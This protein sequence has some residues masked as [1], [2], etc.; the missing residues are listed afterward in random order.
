MKRWG[1][2]LVFFFLLGFAYAGERFSY[3]QTNFTAG[4]LS[5]KMGGRV[6]FP[7]YFNGAK[8]LDNF[9]I[10]P[11]GGVV[12][13]SGF[14][15]IASAKTSN[16]SVRLIPFEFSTTQAYVLELGNEYMRVYK[17]GGVVT[18]VD[19]YTKLLLHG[20]GNDSSTTIIDSGSTVHTVTAYGNAQIDV[21]KYKFG[22]S[23]IL[24]DGY[25]DYLSIPDHDDWHMGTG[26]FSVDMFVMFNSLATHAGFFQQYVNGD[27]YVE[28]YWDGPTGKLW[29]EIAEAASL[30]PS[31]SYS[32]VPDV[33]TWYHLAV[34]R[35]A[36]NNWAIYINGVSVATSSSSADWPDF[37]TALEVGKLSIGTYQYGWIDEFRISKGVDRFPTNFTPPSVEYPQADGGTP[38]EIETPWQTED[39]WDLKYVQSADT[40]WIVH[41]DYKPR[42]LTRTGHTTWNISTYAPT[43]D[44]FTSSTTYPA[45]AAFFEERLCFGGTL[46]SP[47]NIWLSVSG[48]F[49][50]MTTG[51]ETDDAISIAI[52]ADN[53]NTIKWLEP[54]KILVVGTVG[55][56]WKLSSTD[57]NNDP[58]APDD[59]SVRRETTHGSAGVQAET[60]GQNILFVQ[61]AGKKIREFG[62]NFDVDG[63]ISHDLNIL[64]DKIFES[65]VIEMAYQQEPYG[66]VWCVTQNG[67]LYTLTYNKDHEI[68]AWA[69]QPVGG[70][71]VEVK[72]VAVIPGIDEDEV[73]ISVERDISGATYENRA[74]FIERMKPLFSGTD[75]AD[76]FFVDSGL[77]YD[78]GGTSTVSG[79]THLEGETVSILCDG[80]VLSDQVVVDGTLTLGQTCNKVSAGLSYNSNIQ[81]LRLAIPQDPTGTIQGKIKSIDHIT[82]RLLES[83]ECKIGKSASDLEALEFEDGT[84]AF[85][86]DKRIIFDMGY[87]EDAYIYI[88][89]DK[90][91]PLTVLSIMPEVSIGD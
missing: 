73:W 26:A 21:G 17:D 11:Q 41:E 44:P 16:E 60:I 20:D 23:S 67:G 76:G 8:T 53:V 66:I 79:L 30:S 38:Y 12:R 63:W 4:E 28:F 78:G 39:L 22:G 85:S 9:I 15:Y 40:M 32:W 43:S 10:Y 80:N 57:Y 35:G 24:F 81:T 68:I 34:K 46:A 70:V 7:K 3:I 77:S 19:S 25:A 47:Q 36:S 56:E 64:S 13:R 84:T 52:A 1:T 74:N 14:E 5:D 87:D 29:F 45:A 86:G 91:L 71:N 62:Y 90:P 61:R 54:G 82:L 83:L 89:Q 75:V 51:T 65:P 72:S 49:E 37:A 42:K 88:R 55:G 69:T 50:D 59:I 2:L 18:D 58:V 27:N 31:M 48:D 33:N 6:D